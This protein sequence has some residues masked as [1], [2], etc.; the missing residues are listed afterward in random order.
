MHGVAGLVQSLTQALPW[1]PLASG[2]ASC[3]ATVAVRSVWESLVIAGFLSVLLRWMPGLSPKASYRAWGA[4]F[5]LAALLP[6]C[7]PGAI[8]ETAYGAVHAFSALPSAAMVAHRAFPAFSLSPAWAAGLCALWAG[9]SAVALVRLGAGVWSLWR[10]LRTASAAPPAVQAMYRELVRDGGRGSNA[11]LL[12]ADGVAAPCACGVFGPCIV[13]PRGLVESLS[14]EEMEGVLRHEAAH[15][16]RWDD[17]LTVL[18]RCV[19]AVLPLAAAMPYL[20]RRMARAREMACDDAA[21][22][23]GVSRHISRRDYAA[24]LARLAESAGSQ[25]WRRLAPGLGGEGSQ[26]AARVGHILRD[27]EPVRGPGRVRLAAAGCAGVLLCLALLGTPALLSFS[28]RAET[29]RVAEPKLASPPDAAML[30]METIRAARWRVPVAHSRRPAPALAV[31]ATRR[32]SEAHP[33]VEAETQAVLVL[34]TESQD[35]SEG[36]LILLV[37]HPQGSPAAGWPDMFLLKI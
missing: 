35:F 24:C 31:A 5:A 23:P 16:R 27:G 11:R 37:A 22:C 1:K 32:S 36:N 14:L 20:E 10:L 26:L 3:L 12:V 8:S 13:L 21:L 19:R 2:Y 18:A 34:W 25:T 4:G 15:L 17:W 6:L 9:A 33:H 30:P 7:G 29:A 28:S